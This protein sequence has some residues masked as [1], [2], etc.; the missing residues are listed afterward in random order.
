MPPIKVVEV[1]SG[2]RVRVVEVDRSL[3]TNIHGVPVLNKIHI[4]VRIQA[5]KFHFP[6]PS[7][8]MYKATHFP[9]SEACFIEAGV[10]KRAYQA[11]IWREKF[12]LDTK[13]QGEGRE[14]SGV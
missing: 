9:R 11:E 8:C 4:N 6:L 1:S 10:N 2:A 13:R 3:V 5:Y 14:Q 7:L 12:R